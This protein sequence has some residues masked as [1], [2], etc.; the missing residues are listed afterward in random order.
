MTDK[1]L[2]EI[3][4]LTLKYSKK[5]GD[6]RRVQRNIELIIQDIVKGKE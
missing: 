6:L 1:Q 3:L 4:E 5:V 2:K